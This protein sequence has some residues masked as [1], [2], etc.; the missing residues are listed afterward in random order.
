MTKI[1]NG[2]FTAAT[3]KPLVLF[4]IGMR[5]NKLSAVTKWWPAAQAMPAMLRELK[6]R[7]DSGFLGFHTFTSGRTTLV[8]QYWRSFDDLVAYAHDKSGVH[9]PAW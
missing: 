7:P 3:D 2:R 1:F 9:F 5:I 4:L 8:M 6:S